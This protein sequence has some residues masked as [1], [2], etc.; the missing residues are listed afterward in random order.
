[1]AS[2][3]AE[4]DV[5]PPPVVCDLAISVLTYNMHGFNQGSSYLREVCDA[6]VH[7]VIF[8][9]E[10]WLSPALINKITHFSE[11]YVGI[12]KSAMES[13]IST[14]VLKGRPFG[15]V[16]ILVKKDLANFISDSFVFERVV[17]VKLC[18]MLFVNCY[19]PCDDGSTESL[20][21]VNEIVVNISNV[22]D[23]SDACTIVFGGDLNVNLHSDSHHSVAIN[24]FL[25]TYKLQTADVC[26]ESGE[27]LEY[28]YANEKQLKF[29]VIDFICI[30]EC[31]VK[32]VI[33]YNVVHDALNHSD[34]LPVN[35]IINLQPSSS[36]VK[37]I[38]AGVKVLNKPKNASCKQ[39]WLRWDK[40]DV[41]EYYRITGE[42]LYPIFNG[43]KEELR[44]GSLSVD[45]I[46]RFYYSMVDSLLSTARLC[47]PV[48]PQG[49]I[50][51]WWNCDLALL[52]KDSIN[53]HSCWL[54]AGKPMTGIVYDKK[55]SDKLKY[56]NA[57]RKMKKNAEKTTTDQLHE[58][59][60][61]KDS[62]CFWK[63]WKNKIVKSSRSKTTIEGCDSE[64]DAADKFA[65]YFAKTTTPNSDAFNKLKRTEF[66]ENF[67]K[68]KG[69][70]IGNNDIRISVEQ[71]GI[72]IS[73]M[74][75]G[76]A[77]GWDALSVEHITCC[78]PVV[79][80]IVADLFTAMLA[81]GFIPKSFGMGITVP[82]PKGDKV[83]SVSSVESFRGI[84][85]SPIMS[86]WFE[87]CIL[88][89][90]SKYFETS[91]NQFGFKAKLG[92]S[93]AIYVVRRVTDYYVSNNST[94]NLCFLDMAKAFD[95]VNHYV[96]LLKLMKRNIPRMLIKLLYF[97]YNNSF[98][99]VRWENVLSPQYKMLSG[100]RQGGVLSPVLFSIYVDMFLQKICRY[101]CRYSGL[102]FG[103]IMYADDLVLLAPSVTELQSM[104]NVCCNELAL[105]DM[106]INPSKSCAIRIG[107]RWD[108][109][110][111]NLYADREVIHWTKEAKY[112]GIFLLAGRKCKC[113]FE[114]LKSKFYRAA[115]AII[116]KLGNKDN[117]PVTLQLIFTNALP[118]L[119]YG[120]EA[121]LLNKSE[122]QSLN[123][124][125]IRCFEKIF[126]TFDKTVVKQ[127]QLNNGLL[128]VIHYY[129]LKMAS[130]VTKLPK[131]PN[132]LIQ[133]LSICGMYNNDM[134]RLAEL[135]KCSKD[136]LVK[137][138]KSIIY[139]HFEE[140]IAY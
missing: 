42:R 49:S 107:N 109:H 30:S 72:T 46:E 120:I 27:E 29:S 7:D 69:D 124:P 97:W 122:L 21:N 113:K 84:T 43:I 48:V 132:L 4:L 39:P 92:C 1:M 11:H 140:S 9:Q 60:L 114:K 102:A 61:Q 59:L 71:L 38:K 31:I 32:D 136:N 12:G 106:R 24:D 81:N 50:K 103:A 87:H 108:N 77:P 57:L 54:E 66:L 129:G 76:K 82:I 25:S 17:A 138:Y 22:V 115:N 73:K 117:I 85:L 75:S 101:G 123:H 10:H 40:A 80:C 3:H 20:L 133:S 119:T 86:K 89:V 128:S 63:T 18:D 116:A 26:L 135:F 125:W 28:T 45:I 118:V 126:H 52:K 74:G 78:H 67:L 96:L 104:I 98:N 139:G 79:Y 83:S 35:A 137:D 90:F 131:S 62:R 2:I 6:A 134:T 93:H 14:G 23:D 58:A 100:I 37:C 65:E 112:L 41:S 44:L 34:H 33:K 91:V 19:M 95:K 13:V 8:I 56:K 105:L 16:T 51:S 130:F 99:C 68:Y 5:N 53:S 88:L 47:I 55:R 94:V 36:L 127:C 110:Y 64:S 15:G 70:P 111:G 121:L